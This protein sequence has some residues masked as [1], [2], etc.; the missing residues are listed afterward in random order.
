MTSDFALEQ[1]LMSLDL[2]KWT[3][4]KHSLAKKIIFLNNNIHS[5]ILVKN[6]QYYSP[7]AFLNAIKRVLPF[8]RNENRE[9]REAALHFIERWLQLSF[10]I[11]P[12]DF[13]GVITQVAEECNDADVLS[14][15][16]SSIST[17]L[18]LY[19]EDILITIF[20]AIFLDM[21][22]EC[23][24][25]QPQ[26]VY[27]TATKYLSKEQ[28]SSVLDKID[29]P[30]LSD[31]ASI[32]S[33]AHPD[34]LIPKL[35]ESKSYSFL[36]SYLGH[37]K[38]FDSFSIESF[39]NRLQTSI[40]VEE[41][42]DEPRQAVY[43]NTIL[44]RSVKR[45]LNQNEILSLQPIISFA[46]GFINNEESMHNTF[47][48]AAIVYLLLSLAFKGEYD[49]ESIA[50]R[51]KMN[52]ES[53]MEIQMASIVLHSEYYLMTKGECCLSF[54]VLNKAAALRQNQA[55]ICFLDYLC[56]IINEI[57]RSSAICLLNNA[58]FP[59]PSDDKSPLFVLRLL[60]A[61]PLDVL[62]DNSIE[63]DVQ[64][65]IYGY[66]WIND[67]RV[68]IEIEKFIKKYGISIDR[69]RLD[70]FGD[71]SSLSLSLLPSDLFKN[72]IIVEILDTQGI[73][74]VEMPALLKM[75][76]HN[77][78]LSAR[79][80]F[81]HCFVLLQNMILA[82][83]FNL[84]SIYTKYGIKSMLEIDH[85]WIEKSVLSYYFRIIDKEICQTT[86][87]LILKSLIK[88]LTKQFSYIDPLPY[89]TSSLI[90]ICR[91][92]LYALPKQ[93]LSFLSLLIRPSS[94]GLLKSD[95][96][97]MMEEGIN[98]LQMVTIPL[99]F[100][101]I[102]FRIISSHYGL[103]QAVTRCKDVLISAASLD[104]E[105]ALSLVEFLPN[106]P[107]PLR[108][109]LAVS[110][111]YGKEWTELCARVIP[112]NE[113]LVEP[114][115]IEVILSLPESDNRDSI[116]SVFEAFCQTMNEKQNDAN[117]ETEIEK[118]TELTIC[119]GIEFSKYREPNL[120][121]LVSFFWHS[122]KMLP[123]YVDFRTIETFVLTQKNNYRLFVGFLCYAKR[124][125]S[126]IFKEKWVQMIQPSIKTE[127]SIVAAAL[128]LSLIEFSIENPPQYMNNLLQQCSRVL[129]SSYYN[130]I[131]VALASK[132]KRGA[133]AYL[134]YILSTKYPDKMGNF[135]LISAEHSN[136]K[137]YIISFLSQ[138]NSKTHKSILM[139]GI[140]AT[141][142]ISLQ[143][144]KGETCLNFLW[145]SNFDWPYQVLSFKHLN[146]HPK[147]VQIDQGILKAL[148]NA[149]ELSLNLPTV[150]FSFIQYIQVE[151]NYLLM[152][153]R[154][155]QASHR[156]IGY[157]L[158]SYYLK[159]FKDRSTID[160]NTLSLFENRPPSF[161]RAF[162]RS[163]QSQL[164]APVNI[165]IV[166]CIESVICRV[167]PGLCIS[168]CP[169]SFTCTPLSSLRENVI[170]SQIG[171]SAFREMQAGGK[172][173]LLIFEQFISLPL[174]V[175]SSALPWTNETMIDLELSKTII[176]T[177][178]SLPDLSFVKDVF[179]M[180]SKYV[181]KEH[182]ISSICSRE[183]ANETNLLSF[184]FIFS[185]LEKYMRNNETVSP[186]Y[187]IY[188]DPE[189]KVI[190]NQ[191]RR[192]LF[193]SSSKIDIISKVL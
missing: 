28:L 112:S 14:P 102:Y 82:M 128:L 12:V 70:W 185:L 25:F 73:S 67:R 149:S 141:S 32:L 84:E 95:M 96:N 187:E 49:I 86:F 13:F 77:P 189:S 135:R 18:E 43:L 126:S 31:R 169:P 63:F 40:C 116:I 106:T 21:S 100:A 6:S 94:T 155:I 120:F 153:R 47:D 60:N 175:R 71:I 92:L 134:A 127:L 101:N 59:T 174:S 36:V 78:E 183:V 172:E 159:K 2:M 144:Q 104:R 64:S 103:E 79:I 165:G 19:H 34:D 97:Q 164:F 171:V 131:T 160:N 68:F 46:S 167:Y 23:H 24:I 90:V 41:L 20:K 22:A 15:L 178:C 177:A 57:P 130:I 48:E 11:S 105:I 166:K 156:T 3:K 39:L 158:P 65:L 52:P 114:E 5:E 80:S 192:A 180:T 98:E 51:Y 17:A 4:E 143:P 33:Q 181:S 179:L 163:M 10:C 69:S 157:I 110:K 44:L 133:S 26:K 56:K 123:D 99:K 176:K 54:N 53:P 87:G 119:Q 7:T 138:I 83:G 124:N 35:L 8:H 152:L 146:D 184:R 117:E 145:P 129:G 191:E 154:I 186:I 37:I 173:S 148:M 109:F 72:Q 161:T 91:F 182:L 118:S 151:P 115:D 45:K 113:W 27:L 142:S 125:R 136:D 190:T 147:A 88:T 42:T 168:S 66:T 58:L 16:L 85:R 150:F 108:S 93:C 140:I 132:H 1:H 193:Y 74:P 81:H 50:D 89:H 61:T 111:Y 29:N 76:R 30:Q 188:R 121:D 137:E 107:P 122:N 62:K 170:T 139:D 9:V 55:Y 162:Y 75:L 38:D